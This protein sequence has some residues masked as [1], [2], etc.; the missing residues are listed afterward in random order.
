[1]Q[2]RASALLRNK[3]T[4]EYINTVEGIIFKEL[5]HIETY[6]ADEE[7]RQKTRF[8][9]NKELYVKQFEKLLEV[10]PISCLC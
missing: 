9:L 1:M 10:I 7:A 8:V 3:T 5:D 4:F 2:L 6:F